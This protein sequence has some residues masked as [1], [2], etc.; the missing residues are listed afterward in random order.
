VRASFPDDARNV[1]G[2]TLHHYLRPLIQPTSIALVGASERPGSVGRVVLENILA[3]D[4]RGEVLPVNPRH[5]KV[6]GRKSFGS[7]AELP[8]AVD[9]ALICTPPDVVREVL[10][11]GAKAKLKSAVLLTDPPPGDPPVQSRWTRDVGDYAVKHG[12]RVVGPSAFGVIRTD[13]GLNAS[14]SDVPVIP[15]PLALIAQS[16]AVCTAMLDFAAPLGMGFSSVVS[17]GAGIDIN[18]GELLDCLLLDP[19]TE[20]IL[21][22]IESV[23]DARMFVSALRAAARTKP[24]IVL[25]AGRSHEPLEH[26]GAAPL[27][28]EVFDA[29]VRRAGTVRVQTY[30]QL[31]AAARILSTGMIPRGDHLAI[32]ANGRGPA[33]LAADCAAVRHVQLAEFE[34]RTVK[35]LD[36]VLSPDSPR[37]NPVEVRGDPAFA[38]A[39]ATVLEDACVDAVLALH[40]PRPGVGATDAARAVAAVT[41][42]AKKPVLG[43]WLGAID[44]PEVREALE[45]GGIANF[46]T[47]ENAVEAFSF[48]AAYR[49]HQQWLLEVPP[50]QPEPEVP[51]VETAEA[52]R[53]VAEHDGRT[54][55]TEAQAVKLLGA[56]GLVALPASTVRTVEEA[57]EVARHMGYPVSIEIDATTLPPRSTLAARREHLRDGRAVARAFDELATRAQERYRRDWRIGIVVRKEPRGDVHRELSLGVYT[58]PTFGP[59]IAFG[60]SLRGPIEGSERM[61]MLPP[62]NRRLAGDLIDGVHR[63][64]H[65]DAVV[66]GAAREDMLRLLLQVSTLVCALP[67]V[68]ELELDPIVPSPG[69]ATIGGVRAVVDHRRARMPRYAHMAIH[70]YPT[71]LVA[72]VLVRNEI[73]VHIRPIRPEDAELERRFVSGLSEE[74]RYFRFFY[75]LHELSPAMLARFTQVDYDREMALVAVVDDPAA[76]E[77]VSFA[78]VA[79]FIQ[80]PDLESAEYAIVVGD[81]WKGTG[82]ARALMERLIDAARRKGIA[83]LEGAVLRAN[84]NMLRFISRFGFE[85]REDPDD[86]DQY[87]TVLKLA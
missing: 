78:G 83:R 42:G 63:R 81:E 44:R 19:A 65:A 21:L 55:L 41:R 73:L 20:G 85:A 54:L 28:D 51:D 33:L 45:A 67:W 35:S 48:L 84:A 62:L 1:P 6:L 25:K 14:I 80:N 75:R 57:K 27:Q 68:V 30:T 31:F 32:V 34:P 39:V 38:G 52:V 18:F 70:P 15:G 72:D 43:A 66:A 26:V 50:P 40:V 77:G 2:Y 87:Q 24:V 86:Q 61:L 11:A 13:I 79:R 5:R 36:A 29:A 23:R 47:P 9:L 7:L 71:E 59:V 4:F 16:G 8:K 37:R 64:G 60:P 17:I 46:Y 12:I 10:Q 69:A 74:T 82:I 22:Y 58:D 49:R 3:G 56:F 53:A 76:Q